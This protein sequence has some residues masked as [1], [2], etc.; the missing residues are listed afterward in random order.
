L[1]SGHRIH[2]ATAPTKGHQVRNPRIASER[3]DRLETKGIL[4]SEDLIVE[5]IEPA[6]LARTFSGSRHRV[7]EPVP[8][9]RKM[10]EHQR[11]GVTIPGG[12][13]PVCLEGKPLTVGTFEVS[14][15]DDRHRGRF[16][17]E[18]V[19]GE[20]NRL[21]IS[22]LGGAVRSVR[23]VDFRTLR[24][25]LGPEDHY[26]EHEGAARE[27]VRQNCLNDWCTRHAATPIFE[28]EHNSGT[29]NRDSIR[30]GA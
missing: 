5:P 30:N 29:P 8:I 12:Y 14:E 19:T 9:Q 18:S 21:P 27:N 6:L 11:N 22:D 16:V 23:D 2:R 24:P 17:P 10:P 25:E 28:G 15:L 1:D 13:G 20:C 3:I 26:R 7:S 4:L